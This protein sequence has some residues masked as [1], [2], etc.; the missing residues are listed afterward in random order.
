MTHRVIRG[1]NAQQHHPQ[2]DV[3]SY[4]GICPC[5]RKP[6]SIDIDCHSLSIEGGEGLEGHHDTGISSSS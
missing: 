5:C 1:L 4:S 3:L 6:L 2:S